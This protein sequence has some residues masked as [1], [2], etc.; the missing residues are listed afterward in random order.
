MRAALSSVVVMI[1]VTTAAAGVDD[2]IAGWT[3]E[4]GAGDVA[5]DGGDGT[6]VGLLHG[7]TSVTDLLMLMSEWGP[8]DG[9]GAADINN[10]GVVDV[11]DLLILIQYWT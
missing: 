8:C 7:A 9:C 5:S 2:H 1:M 4:E 11:T 3:F 6:I 10:D